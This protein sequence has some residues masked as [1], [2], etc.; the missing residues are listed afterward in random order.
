VDRAAAPGQETHTCF[1]IHMSH[2]VQFAI[3]PQEQPC[4]RELLPIR[5]ARH[6]LGGTHAKFSSRG[7]PQGQ[8]PPQGPA[9]AKATTTRGTMLGLSWLERELPRII[10]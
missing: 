6:P 10:K 9:L 8:L 3:S 5:L 7:R 4:R 2:P 1:Y